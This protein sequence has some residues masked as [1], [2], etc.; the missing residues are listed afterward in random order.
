MAN[1]KKLA[2][3]AKQA[4]K[5]LT[6]FLKKN[7]LKRDK[8]YSKD[9][10]LGTKWKEL[11]LA[12][13]KANDALEPAAKPAAEKT[14][15]KETAK[16]AKEKKEKGNAGSGRATKYEYPEGLTAAEKK[17]FRVKARRDAKGGDKKDK[18]SKGKT[19][20]VTEKTK[21]VADSKKSGKDAKSKKD[22]SKKK[23]GKND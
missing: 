14:K 3:N 19:E 21:P 5:A 12:A 13:D 7:N 17:E 1:A 23:S 8:D 22:K 18:A 2:E 20:K 9:A 10:K 11:K 15:A 16:P 4:N 6:D